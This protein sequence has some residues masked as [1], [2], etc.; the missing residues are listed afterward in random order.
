MEAYTGTYTNSGYTLGRQSFSKK[1]ENDRM[2]L[3]LLFLY[4]AILLFFCSK[5]SPL[6][7]INEWAD[8]NL[9]FN[10][11][12]CF[13]DGKVLYVDTFDHKGPVIF[14]IYALGYLISN[15]S[16][17]G[18]FIIQVLFWSIM[19]FAAYYTAKL[20]LEN[21]YAFLVALAFPVLVLMRTQMGGSA[22]EFILVFMSISTYCFVSYFKESLHQHKPVF[23]F[24]H[25][26]MCSLVFFTK[27][28]LIV[29]WV[30]PLSAIFLSLLLK[31]EFRNLLKNA[32]ALIGGFLI[33]A[34]PIFLY[35]Y[36]NDATN[37]AYHIYIEL[38]R[39]YANVTSFFVKQRFYMRLR[40]DFP[41]F[42]I[43]LTGVLAFPIIYLKNWLGNIALILS[44]LCLFFI[45][46]SSFNYA[47][48]YAIPYYIFTPLGCIV[49]VGLLSKYI[50]V[51][52]KWIVLLFFAAVCVGIGIK[53]KN[54]FGEDRRILQR[55]E[56][57]SGVVFRF[58][59]IIKGDSERTLINL[60]NDMGNGVFTE[61][62]IHPTVKYF[63]TPNLTHEAFPEMRDEQARYMQEGLIKYVILCEACPGCNYF[64]GHESL[65]QNYD[66]IDQYIDVSGGHHV[67][68]TL[69]RRKEDKVEIIGDSVK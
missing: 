4:V 60:G 55:Q 67:S 41:D 22:E 64:T 48:Y 8:V 2:Y 47:D 25:G 57:P 52:P 9:Y 18:M 10:I 30:F 29:F 61:A 14:F 5:M 32:V 42:A 1:I 66:S 6:Y 13:T 43:I 28:S 36:L 12:K 59:E 49:I 26:V 39:E 23:M 19:L 17:L 65:V 27:L 46:N 34:L 56:K 33:I 7:P 51:Q 68:Y 21:Q 38:N 54:Y 63:V 16:F 50:A 24:I 20:F 37:N 31:K 44:F 45:V 35:L 3:I 62:D 69:F 53:E 40:Y 11:G 15:A 58:S